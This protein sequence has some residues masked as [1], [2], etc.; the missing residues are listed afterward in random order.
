MVAPKIGGAT[1]SDG[2]LVPANQKIDGG[3]SVLYDAVAVLASADG[4]AL[5]AGD[6]AAKDFITDAHAHCKFIGHVPSAAAL[7][8]AA[9]L[10][11]LIDEGYIDL[12]SSGVDAF[13]TA[14]RQLRYWQREPTVD[15]I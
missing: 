3:P 4:A 1:L 13:V 2:S 8:Q 6:A 10:A 15:A 7:V 14:C 9:G 12:E 5:L 11:G